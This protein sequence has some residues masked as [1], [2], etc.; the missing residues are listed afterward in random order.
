MLKRYLVLG[1]LLGVAGSAIAADTSGLQALD[2]VLNSLFD[3]SS[4]VA[5]KSPLLDDGKR[6]YGYLLLILISWSGIQVVLE[7]GA[8][9]AVIAYFAAS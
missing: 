8:L 2:R 9:N 3:I 7:G 5:S 6:L 4:G 1:I